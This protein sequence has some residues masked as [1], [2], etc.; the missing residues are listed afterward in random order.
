MLIWWGCLEIYQ[1]FHMVF[2]FSLTKVW[3]PLH[4]NHD[5]EG[6]ADWNYSNA[7][8]HKTSSYTQIIDNCL[9]VYTDGRKRWQ[10]ARGSA[11]RTRHSEK[12]KWCHY[13][14]QDKTVQGLGRGRGEGKE[15][16]TTRH[17]LATCQRG[18]CLHFDQVSVFKRVVR[19]AL[20][21]REVAYTV[22]DW[23][24]GGERNACKK[25]T[26]SPQHKAFCKILQFLKGLTASVHP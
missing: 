13:C 4:S 24:A 12:A 15:R 11:R 21:G 16:K 2:A 9:R 20:Q 22:I 26:T 19:V 18:S 1:I 25:T 14:T 10:T 3:I 5:H 6:W 23:H 8:N 17:R 7:Y